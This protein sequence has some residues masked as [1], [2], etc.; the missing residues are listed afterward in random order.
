MEVNIEKIKIMNLMCWRL[1]WW[2][3]TKLQLMLMKG[4]EI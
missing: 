4:N 1:F 3:T 2:E